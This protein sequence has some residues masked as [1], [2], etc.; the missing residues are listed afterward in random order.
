[1]NTFNQEVKTYL[2]DDNFKK[3]FRAKQE[4]TQ[5]LNELSL[6]RN[7]TTTH[8]ELKLIKTQIDSFIAVDSYFQEF[9]GWVYQKSSSITDSSLKPVEIRLFYYYLKI[10]FNLDRDRIFG[11]INSRKLGVNLIFKVDNP[12]KFL[13]INLDHDSINPISLDYEL[14]LIYFRTSTRV[15]A[16][17]SGLTLSQ[18]YSYG[19]VQ[20]RAIALASVINP[21]L[22]RVIEGFKDIDP[23]LKLKLEDLQFQLPNIDEDWEACVQWELWWES[24]GEAWNQKLQI[25]IKEHRN[26]GHDWQ[27]IYKQINW[28]YQYYELNQLLRDYLNSNCWLGDDFRLQFENTL[29]VPISNSLNRISQ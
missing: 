16:R 24:V 23:E 25:I 17:H 9:L 20:E 8:A 5:Q 1:M 7:Q 13:G 6:T 12:S 21:A 19:Y 26:L 27:F 15:Q 4:I 2:E 28:L 3:I 22:A 29:L 18:V 11:F 10:S 14:A